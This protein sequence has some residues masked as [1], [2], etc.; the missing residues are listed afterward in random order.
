MIHSKERWVIM[1][2]DR[3]FIA[4][5]TPRNRYLIRVDNEKD[6]KR[7]MT[8]SSEAM[9]RSAFTNSGFYGSGPDADKLEAVKVKVTMEEISESN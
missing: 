1:S 2:K 8:Y 7:V 9:A 6:K 3:Q 5:G 4:K